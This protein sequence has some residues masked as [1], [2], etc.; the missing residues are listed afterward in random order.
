[1]FASQTSVCVGY[2]F[3]AQKHNNKLENS[4]IRSQRST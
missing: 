1:M 4:E 2:P 3:A